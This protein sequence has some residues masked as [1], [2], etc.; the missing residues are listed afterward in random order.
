MYALM[1]GTQGVTFVKQSLLPYTLGVFPRDAASI[2]I[3]TSRSLSSYNQTLKTHIVMC[4]LQA[5]LPQCG[6]RHQSLRQMS[7]GMIL[8]G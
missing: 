7:L 6:H 3:V 4:L 8:S 5:T 1:V 2:C